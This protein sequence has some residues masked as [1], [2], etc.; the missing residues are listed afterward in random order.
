MYVHMFVYVYALL[1]LS[2]VEF[3]KIN[4]VLNSVIDIMRLHICSR[5]NVIINGITP[6][7]NSRHKN[8]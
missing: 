4:V 1:F 8:F 2:L 5:F 6:F 7:T 3:T